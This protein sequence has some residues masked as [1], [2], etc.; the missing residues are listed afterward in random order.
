MRNN[1]HQVFVYP[2]EYSIVHENSF[3]FRFHGLFILF[4]MRSVPDIDRPGMND[5]EC[6]HVTDKSSVKNCSYSL[7]IEWIVW[8]MRKQLL[9][10][11]LR[12]AHCGWERESARHTHSVKERIRGAKSKSRS[13]AYNTHTHMRWSVGFWAF[14]FD[15]VGFGALFRLNVR[16]S[17]CCVSFH[18]WIRSPHRPIN[19]IT[20]KY[21]NN[22]SFLLSFST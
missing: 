9:Y 6:F 18:Q 20:R 17:V 15:S 3:R 11:W 1:C 12:R 21:L 22:F 2:K 7:N 8:K 5:L 14:E 10:T 16:C 13:R 19:L 4:H